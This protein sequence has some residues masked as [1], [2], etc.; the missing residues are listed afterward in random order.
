[1]RNCILVAL[2]DL[3]LGIY[4]LLYSVI[5]EQDSRAAL[6]RNNRRACICKACKLYK[7]VSHIVRYRLKWQM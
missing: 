2:S 5:S 1:M 6:H 4:S 3:P 7:L